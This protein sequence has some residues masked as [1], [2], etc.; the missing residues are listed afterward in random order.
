VRQAHLEFARRYPKLVETAMQPDLDKDQ[1]EYLLTMFER[2]QTQRVSF[3]A[4]SHQVGRTMFDTYLAP[5]LTPEQLAAVNAKVG[6][7]ERTHAQGG[8]GAADI[9]RMAAQMAGGGTGGGTG[10][11]AATPAATNRAARRAKVRGRGGVPK[12]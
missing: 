3:D 11:T 8:A 2:V 6:D 4:A 12:A 9:A 1:L 5:N 7:L 10:P